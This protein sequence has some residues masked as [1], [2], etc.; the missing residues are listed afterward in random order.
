MVFKVGKGRVQRRGFLDKARG[1]DLERSEAMVYIMG[2]CSQ[3]T[4][5]GG[6]RR[7]SIIGWRGLS[8]LAG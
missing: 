6:R 8:T 2:G 5:Q 1:N 7:S 3:Y 4:S